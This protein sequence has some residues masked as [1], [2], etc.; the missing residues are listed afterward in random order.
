MSPGGGMVEYLGTPV[1]VGVVLAMLAYG[2]LMA[3]S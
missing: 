1:L 3:R 2:F